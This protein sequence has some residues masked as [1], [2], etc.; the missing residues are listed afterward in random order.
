MNSREGYSGIEIP[1]AD[2]THRALELAQ[3][4]CFDNIVRHGFV[5]R[6]GVEAVF[7]NRD[8]ESSPP[9]LS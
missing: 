6:G 9:P 1:D 2:S 3:F 8:S 7:R 5:V 4:A